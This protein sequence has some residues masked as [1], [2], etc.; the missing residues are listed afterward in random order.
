MH[1]RCKH[2]KPQDAGVASYDDFAKLEKQVQEL[3]TK[4]RPAVVGVRMSNS[5]G[6]GSFISA[7]GWIATCAHV[8]EVRPGVKCKIIGFGSEEFEGEVY[9][10]DMAMDFGLIKADTKGK[11]VPFVELGDSDKV[12]NG[13]WLISMGHPLGVEK[14]RDGV[15]RCGRV[16]LAKNRNGFITMDTPVIHGDSGGP[17]FD[18]SGKQVGINQSISGMD[19]RINNATPVAMFKS[20]LED[21]K[22]KKCLHPVNGNPRFGRGIASDGLTD[23]E[24]DA[25]DRAMKQ[26]GEGKYD[27]AHKLVEPFVNKKGLD[28]GVLYNLA[29]ILSMLSTKQKGAEQEASQKKAVELFKA[30]IEAGW[31]DIDHM[32]KD[33]DLDGLRQRKDYLA[34]ED[35]CAKAKVKPLLGLG[36]R[37][38]SGVRVSDIIPGSPADKAGLRKED[39][40]TKIGK[41]KISGAQ[42]Y[43]DT[44][45]FEG[46][47]DAPVTVSRKKEKAPEIKLTMPALGIKVIS[48]GGAQVSEVSEDGLG[49]KAGL[50][51]NDI[52][53][54]VG[55]LKIKTS[56]DFVNALMTGDARSAIQLSVKRGYTTEIVPLTLGGSDT[57]GA[58]TT[59]FKQSEDLLKLWDKVSVKYQDAVFSV[60]Q[61][62]KQVTFATAVDARGY[63][64][65]KASELV[66]NEK[67]TLVSRSG[68]Q[69]EATLVGSDP[70]TDIAMLHT[71][72]TLVGVIN[73][74]PQQFPAVGTLVGSLDEKGHVVAYGFVALPPYDTDKNARPMPNDAVMGVGVEDAPGGVKV[75]AVTAGQPA[76]KGGLK[77]GDVIIKID[78]AAMPSREAFMDFMREKAPGNVI[79]LEVKRGEAVQKLK[80]TLGARKDMPGG[81]GAGPEQKPQGTGKPDLGVAT[82][83][84]ANPGLMVGGV[85]DG[86]PAELAGITEGDVILEAD[87]KPVGSMAE[88]QAIVDAHKIGDKMK[89]KLL[90]NEKPLT[91]EVEIAEMEAP[92][93]PNDAQHK[94]PTNTRCDK[95][96][97]CIQHDALLTP[98]QMG[99]PIIDLKGNVVG[100]NLARSDRTRNFALPSARVADVI[101]KL[102]PQ[103]E[104]ETK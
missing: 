100:L 92:P 3:S 93:N 54:K 33:T 16:L 76:D 67:I 45:L 31:D 1:F 10:S 9:G 5:S 17:T 49:Y 98:R 28:E 74:G 63:L 56:I 46:L 12:K 41:T 65:C 59:V 32:R 94:G 78:G 34:V 6:S 82:G 47:K 42:E 37:V 95:F 72:G 90:R 14:G 96:G 61:K 104:T 50:K 53:T 26:H 99:G 29:C 58:A 86:S 91:L 68:T 35:M 89:L 51:L 52:I 75:T 2:P 85:R 60:K 62:G 25:Y 73:F 57:G 84:P 8:C 69:M 87:D 70:R 39:V 77:V 55:T 43:A 103:G 44:L 79:E 24:R 30:S 27:Q 97:P 36:V 80:V 20:Q 88:L 64:L 4:L 13:Q 83:E 48:S 40:I 101:K 38:S 18:L 71:K 7:D 19:A 81:G 15:V 102:M 22:A 66:D 23:A 11:K 21:M